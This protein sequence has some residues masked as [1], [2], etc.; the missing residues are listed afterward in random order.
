MGGGPSL[1]GPDR[2]SSG[3]S[4]SLVRA[5]QVHGRGI[6]V[7]RDRESRP[8]R[9][10]EADIIVSDA[11]SVAL[12]VQTADCVP[13]LMADRRSGVI[14]AAHAGWRGLAVKVPATA[15]EALAREFGSRPDDLIAAVGPAIGACCYEIGLEVRER[16]DAGGFSAPEIERWFHERPQP[17][18]RNPSMPA[19]SS[20]ARD[21][22][23]FFDT[24]R[25]TRDQLAAAGVPPA[26]IHVAEV[27]T[28]SHELLCSYRR[29]GKGAGRMA[30]AISR[31]TPPTPRP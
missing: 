23:W 7:H 30:G 6:L 22:R 3:V 19:L 1:S 20:P 16:F 12:A 25:A 13:L 10:P 14:A 24:W 29:D 28:A 31:P 17:T 9:P 26:Q 21:G 8:P 18:A 11:T 15:V 27:C 2:M 5:H 4:C